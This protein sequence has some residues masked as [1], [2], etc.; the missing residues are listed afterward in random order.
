MIM[1]RSA[2]PTFLCQQ[3]HGSRMGHPGSRRTNLSKLLSGYRLHFKFMDNFVASYPSCH[4]T[5]FGM[6]IYTYGCIYLYILQIAD[7]EHMVGRA[8]TTI[9]IDTLTI[10]PADW[11]S[12]PYLFAIVKLFTSHVCGYALPTNNATSMAAALFQYVCAFSLADHVCTDPGSEFTFKMTFS[13]H[14]LSQPRHPEADQ[15]TL[16]DCL[17]PRGQ[18]RR[19]LRYLVHHSRY[20]WSTAYQVVHIRC[21][22]DRMATHQ[23]GWANVSGIRWLKNCDLLGTL[24]D[25]VTWWL[26]TYCG[27][28]R[29]PWLMTCD[30][31]QFDKFWRLR[32]LR[33]KSFAI[34][35]QNDLISGP[36]FLPKGRFSTF[37]KCIWALLSPADIINQLDELFHGETVF[38]ANLI[39]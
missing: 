6:N 14:L 13:L 24:P 35:V 39:I 7:A 1:I 30:L 4:T 16:E 22:P 36:I 9:G 33:L 12:S 37:R 20:F 8:L 21:P 3:A 25:W 17:W 38:S 23:Q 19:T 29:I 11:L 32:D 10:S 31:L 15:L 27:Q 2:D 34:F 26:V 5:R 18:W 28:V